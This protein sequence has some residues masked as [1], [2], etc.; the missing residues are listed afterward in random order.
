MEAE[1]PPGE[2]GSNKVEFCFSFLASALSTVAVET[3]SH[4]HSRIWLLRRLSTLLEFHKELVEFH[5]LVKTL[6]RYIWLKGSKVKTIW[7]ISKCSQSIIIDIVDFYRLAKIHSYL[8]VEPFEAKVWQKAT[9]K[10]HV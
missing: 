4:S 2:W 8:R 5:F 9:C 1:R 10:S 6:L 7:P 3:R